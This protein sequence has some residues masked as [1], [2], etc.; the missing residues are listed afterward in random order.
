MHFLHYPHYMAKFNSYI[1]HPEIERWRELCVNEGE[2]YRYSKGEEFVSIGRVA[3]YIGYVKS[4]TLKYIAYDDN[5]MEHVVGLEF[6]R[7]FVADFPFSLRGEPSR[8]SIIADSECEIY[9]FPVRI[10]AERIKSDATLS[11]LVTKSTELLFSQTYN[12]YL[13]LYCQSP[14]QRYQTLVCHHQDI[15]ERFSLKDIA[16]FLNVTPTYLSRIRKKLAL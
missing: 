1:E 2:L 7:E 14:E 8:V 15:F 6:A 13:S 11:D 3:R 5:G 10:L 12:R 16:S 4:G 9:R